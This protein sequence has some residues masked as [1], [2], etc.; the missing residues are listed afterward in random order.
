MTVPVGDFQLCTICD[1]DTAFF[2]MN[3]IFL[4]DQRGKDLHSSIVR[5][6]VPEDFYARAQ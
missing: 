3:N 5:W 2:S 4:F 1:I 6:H